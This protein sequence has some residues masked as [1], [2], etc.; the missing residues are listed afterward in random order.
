MPKL[1]EEEIRRQIHYHEAGA[2]FYTKRGQTWL[3]KFSREAANDLRKQLPQP[4]K[5]VRAVHDGKM[6]AA[7]GE[8]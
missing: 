1:S 3:A 2:Q 4:P 7:G 8:S 6:A 5:P